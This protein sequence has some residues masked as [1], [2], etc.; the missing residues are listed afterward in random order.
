MSKADVSAGCGLG[1]I[2]E[3][4]VPQVAEEPIFKFAL[5]GFGFDESA[6]VDQVQIEPAV[7]VKIDPGNA[8]TL[9]LGNIEPV[10]DFIVEVGEVNPP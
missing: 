3:V 9:D 4:A 5:I 2:G 1:D 8:A 10:R 6:A 7:G